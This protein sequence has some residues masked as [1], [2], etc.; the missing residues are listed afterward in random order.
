MTSVVVR[1]G[2]IAADFGG[3]EQFQSEQ[4]FTGG[5]GPIQAY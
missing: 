2:A 1:G 4:N 3:K 5:K